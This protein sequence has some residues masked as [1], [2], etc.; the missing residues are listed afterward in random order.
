MCPGKAFNFTHS[1]QELFWAT[2]P[3]CSHANPHHIQASLHLWASMIGKSPEGECQDF[4]RIGYSTIELEQCTS[5]QTSSV[6]TVERT[7][8]VQAV[9]STHNPVSAEAL[10]ACIRASV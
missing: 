2:F 10:L 7:P 5:R 1:I 3:A 6:P 4:V 8:G 9:S